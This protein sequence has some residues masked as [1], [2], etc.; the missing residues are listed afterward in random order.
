VAG[1]HNNLLM[2]R[3]DFTPSARSEMPFVSAKRSAQQQLIT[4]KAGSHF[5]QPVL[6]SSMR[7]Q[8]LATLISMR[9]E[10]IP[11]LEVSYPG[12]YASYGTQT[13]MLLPRSGASS[14]QGR[15]ENL[16]RLRSTQ[17]TVSDIG[18]LH[19]P[20]SMATEMRSQMIASPAYL[21]PFSL[22]QRGIAASRATLNKRSAAAD[23]RG[24]LRRSWSSPPLDSAMPLVSKKVIARMPAHSEQGVSGLQ[25]LGPPAQLQAAAVSSEGGGERAIN[26]QTQTAVGQTEEATPPQT[27]LEALADKLWQKIQRKLTIERE[28]RGLASWP[29]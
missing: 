25:Q 24:F 19:K 16:Q 9:R 1:N 17:S 6:Q 21:R 2:R 10:A 7:G 8:A 27:D 18:S 12:A 26:S 22:D 13:A 14:S 28:R 23:M 5:L 20:E 3:A 15:L 11:L 4:G 29:V